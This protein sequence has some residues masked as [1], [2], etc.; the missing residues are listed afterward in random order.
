M[1]TYIVTYNRKLIR[2]RAHTDDDAVL[3]AIGVL[4]I[5]PWNVSKM[6]VELETEKG[7]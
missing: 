3:K 6:K 1:N 4:N 5:K 2:V 7:N